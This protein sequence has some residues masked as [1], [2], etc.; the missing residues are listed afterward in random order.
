[1]VSVM[2][3]YDLKPVSDFDN[4][5]G[6]EVFFKELK[7]LF[8]K[9]KTSEIKYQKWLHNQFQMLDHNPIEQL[10]QTKNFELLSSDSGWRIYS[11]RRPESIGNPRILFSVVTNEIGRSHIMLLAFK[12]LHNDYHRFIPIARDRMKHI[13]ENLEE[14]ANGYQ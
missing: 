9:D 4:I 7:D 6:C 14:K 2:A 11:L 8:K 5:F 1:M 13:M 12:E 10:I 3:A